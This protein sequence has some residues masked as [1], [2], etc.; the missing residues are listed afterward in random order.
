MSTFTHEAG[1]NLL[2]LDGHT[3]LANEVKL[4]ADYISVSVR[5]A[6]PAADHSPATTNASKTACKLPLSRESWAEAT[7]VTTII[8]SS[9][10]F[11]RSHNL[12]EEVLTNTR[13]IATVLNNPNV[14]EHLNSTGQNSTLQAWRGK[15]LNAAH[16]ASKAIATRATPVYK[17]DEE[18]RVTNDPE[19]TAE[20][21]ERNREIQNGGQL[22]LNFA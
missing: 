1:N 8:I 10:S 22:T 12:P 14:E 17:T 5:K 19:I 6:S 9:H 20:V 4:H 11:R 18:L 3:V 15:L 2:T 21:R 16:K 7:D 13:R